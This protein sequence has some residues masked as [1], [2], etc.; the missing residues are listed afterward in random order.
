M[1]QSNGIFSLLL[2][3]RC[4]FHFGNKRKICSVHWYRFNGTVS[5]CLNFGCSLFSL[6]LLGCV[7]VFLLYTF[8]HYSLCSRFHLAPDFY[9]T[10]SD[11][12]CF[13]AMETRRFLYFSFCLD[14]TL[15][16]S[17]SFLF[18][19]RFVF[20][21]SSSSML[22]YF[23]QNAYLFIYFWMY[24]CT[25]RRKR[26]ETIELFERNRK[27]DGANEQTKQNKFYAMKMK[28]YAAVKQSNSISLDNKLWE[29]RLMC[30][31][32]GDF[33]SH[34]LHTRCT[35]VHQTLA[36]KKLFEKN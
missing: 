31:N 12:T 22:Y 11:L 32:R 20:F 4:K 30:C 18:S 19:I 16:Y 29:M 10:C 27:E 15:A 33:I 14:S 28:N 9:V 6:C 35:K 34:E 36:F 5:T 25:L 26:T 8:D 21:S 1:Y 17:R 24:S 2:S 3:D 7:R 23:A 13:I